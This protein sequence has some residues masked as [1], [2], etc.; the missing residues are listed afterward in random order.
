MKKLKKLILFFLIIILSYIV[1]VNAET[2][3]NDKYIEVEEEISDLTEISEKIKETGAE[4]L[5]IQNGQKITSLEPLKDCTSLKGIYIHNSNITQIPSLKNLTNLQ[6]LDL[7][8]SKKLVDISGLSGMSS[9]N[10]LWL[11][12]CNVSDISALSNIYTLESLRITNS[13]ITDISCL[14]N[15][16]NL[17][18]IYLDNNN[19]TDISVVSNFSNLEV[20][21]IC[22]NNV[23]DIKAI[24]N[25]NKLSYLDFGNNKITDISYISVDNIVNSSDDV[26]TEAGWGHIV[27]VSNNYIDFSKQKNK[28]I[29][30]RF[31][32]Y[33]WVNDFEEQDGDVFQYVPQ[34]VLENNVKV[35]KDNIILETTTDVIPS[36]T[37]LVVENITEGNTYNN[38]SKVLSSL[39]NKFIAYDIT[40]MK[41][42]K[43]IQPNGKVKLSM[44]IPSDFDTSKLVVYR[45]EEDGTKVEY[46]VNIVTIDG[47]QYAQFET[48]HFSNYVLVEKVNMQEE[49]QST[50]AEHKLDNEPKTGYNISKGLGIMLLI[51]TTAFVV[52][53]KKY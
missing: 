39:A 29:I 23:K 7:S 26:D 8:D 32:K 31:A 18:S 28:D 38:I 50:Q 21:S 25:L 1:P 49:N 47:K 13:N 15:L 16:K 11:Y 37:S 51:A 36:N 12:D 42:N 43:E 27:I 10:L 48:D 30:D 52:A 24:A 34:K 46:K 9:L 41:D 3:S 17:N 2:M 44:P 40:L 22:N 5:S 33:N 35:S 14:K 4:T 19:I 53:T 6:Y 20:L 45:I